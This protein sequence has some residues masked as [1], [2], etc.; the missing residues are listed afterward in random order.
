MQIHAYG[1]GLVNFNNRVTREV[2]ARVTFPDGSPVGVGFTAQLYGGPI[3]TSVDALVPLFPT[4]TFRLTS[5]QAM[6]YVIGVE[7]VFQG[8]QPGTPATVQMRVF[9]GA[10]W[11]TS[12]CRGESNPITVSL[13]G[14]N[15]TPTNLVG[16]QPFQ[17]NCIPEP[18]NGVLLVCGVAGLLAF[19]RVR[20]HSRTPHRPSGG[21]RA[22]P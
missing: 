14:G 4:T 6:G 11:E 13:F 5:T 15:G 8:M 17:V 9:D 2:D 22:R 19:R 21:T 20:R 12:V 1:Q 18:G 16:M 10:T 7:V 3:G